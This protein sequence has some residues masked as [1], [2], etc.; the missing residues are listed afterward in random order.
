MSPNLDVAVVRSVPL[1]ERFENVNLMP[2]EMKSPGQGHSAMVSMLLDVNTHF[3]LRGTFEATVSSA[4]LSS[5]AVQAFWQGLRSVC[6]CWAYHYNGASL[7][8][9]P[10]RGIGL[11][12]IGERR[13]PA[14]VISPMDA[15]R[16]SVETERKPVE[17]PQRR[18]R[19]A[20]ARN[21][22][23]PRAKQDDGGQNQSRLEPRNLA[24][25]ADLEFQGAWF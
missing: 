12:G 17:G 8:R 22:N 11:R 25:A 14:K 7:I 20:S 10:A 1:I 15:L 9:Y 3:W 21:R 24:L 23:E 18:H 5:A 4:Q 19:T 2:A 6:R 13:E 16:R